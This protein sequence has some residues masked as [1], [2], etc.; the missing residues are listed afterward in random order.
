MRAKGVRLALPRELRGSALL[1]GV[2]VTAQSVCLYSAVALIPVAL[3]LLVFQTSAI[4]Y[5]LLAWA[6]GKETPRP[7]VLV[8]M[9]VCLIGLSFA[10]DVRFEELGARWREMGV[11]VTW[12]FAGA[13]SMMFV[14]YMNANAL[15]AVDGRLRTFVMT[16]VT[17]VLVVGG[18][19]A[20]NKLAL[21]ADGTGWIGIAL[22]T[23][24]YCIAMSTMFMVLPHLSA[25]STAALAFEPIA[26][27]GLAWLVLG[28][29]VKPLQI[30]GA[31]V[32]VGALGWIG[33]SKR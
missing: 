24:F 27:L 10:L 6:M 7:S 29:A 26:L 8:A 21:P 18:G 9:V 23:F 30:L 4:L 28:Q 12:A 5:V 32:T 33:M 20:A 22:L 13:I 15:R 31:F 17:A 25:A 2:L 3:A 1:A 14:Y 16:G 11:G 19:A